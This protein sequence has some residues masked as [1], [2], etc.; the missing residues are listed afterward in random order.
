L[1]M[2]DSTTAGDASA[3]TDVELLIVEVPPTT[4]QAL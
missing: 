3:A 2:P 4:N 1:V